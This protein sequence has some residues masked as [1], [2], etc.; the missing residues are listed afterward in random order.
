[1]T[2]NLCSVSEVRCV[3]V[4]KTPTDNHMSQL[5]AETNIEIANKHNSNEN[6]ISSKSA[7]C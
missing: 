4:G 2:T 3:L 7:M 1:M 5:D 6:I